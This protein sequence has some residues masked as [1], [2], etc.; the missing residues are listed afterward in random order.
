MRAT[1]STLSLFSLV[2][3]T[4]APTLSEDRVSPND[5]RTPA[6]V[7][8]EGILTLHL[9]ARVAMWHPNGDDAPGALIPAFAEEGKAPQIPGPLVRVPAGTFVA[10]TVRNTLAHDTLLVRGL[11]DRSSAP[12]PPASNDSLRLAP[13][14]AR[15]IRMRLDA[16]GTYYY[17]GTTT[18]RDVTWRTREDAQLSGAIVV[19]QAGAPPVRDRI[20]VIGMWTDTVARAYVERRRVLAVINGRT[21][22]NTE[23][24][25]YTVGDTVRFRVINAS[26]DNHPMHLHGFYFRVDSRGDGRGDTTYSADAADRGVTESI[27]QGGTM[28]MTW[29]PERAGNWLFHCHIPEHFSQRGPL[30]MARTPT[31]SQDHMANH[32]TDDMGGLVMGIIV[33]SRGVASRPAADDRAPRRLRLLVRRNAGGSDATPNFGFAIQEGASVPPPDTGLRVGPPSSSRAVSPS[34]FAS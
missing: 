5:N 24:L 4:H 6:G 28:S 15:S 32:A 29:V 9:E 13:G 34:P 33:G 11:I 22:P 18:G 1:L 25:H 23:R 2:V 3:A 17:W 19:D 16:P 26:G 7:L 20:L 30:G 10:L 21:W 14:E 8:S 27:S 31:M 12:T